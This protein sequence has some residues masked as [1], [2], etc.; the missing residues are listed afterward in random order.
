MNPKYEGLVVDGVRIH[1]DRKGFTVEWI[2]PK[3]GFGEVTIWMGED[4]KLHVDTECMDDEF[5]SLVLS[6]IMPLMIR[7]D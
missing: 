6:K 1:A 3:L 7:E 2:A 5:V 4:G